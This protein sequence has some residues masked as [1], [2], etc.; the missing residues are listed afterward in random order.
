MLQ[1]QECWGPSTVSAAAVLME[2]GG[3]EGAE[4]P[5]CDAEGQGGVS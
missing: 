2:S 3:E 4:D 1:E 5:N